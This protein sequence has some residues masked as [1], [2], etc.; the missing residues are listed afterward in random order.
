VAGTHSGCG[1]TSVTLGLMAAFVRRGM[2]VQGFKAGPD[3]IDPGHHQAVTGRASHNLDGWMTDRGTVRATF[4]RAAASCS[5]AVVEGVMGLYDG[6]SGTSDAGSAAQLARWLD[7]PVILVVDARSMARSAAAVVRGFAD[8]DSGVRLAGVVFNRVGSPRHREILEQ[9]MTGLDVPLLG[10]LDR[11]EGLTPPSRH[12]GLLTA[13]EWDW[14]RERKDA[15]AD[16]VERGMDL[17]AFLERLP[18]K[19]VGIAASQEPP[20]PGVRIG[21]AWDPAFCFYYEENLRLLRLA[22]AELVP[23]SPMFDERL[24]EDLDGLYLGGGYPEVYGQI[25]AANSSM[26]AAIREFSALNRPVYGECGGYMY[27]AREL[28][29]K[30]GKT[31]PMA[32]VF[33]GSCVMQS[34]FAALGYRE[35]RTTAATLLGPAGT[36]VRG[37]EFHYSRTEGEAAGV[38]VYRVTDRRGPNAKSRGWLVNRTLGSYVHLHFGACPQSAEYFVEACVK[39][40]SGR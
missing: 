40:R 8:F 14:S 22:G 19:A 11:E 28:T 13:G 24:P 26:R 31:W 5:A 1:K 10:C 25:L 9:A 16:W 21:L 3:F 6:F 36:V 32:G 35:V 7:L 15:L 30:A 39:A 4:E 38:S 29:D 20:A 33:D 12:L 34:R 27:L 17:D 2:R 37:H 18:E 23:F